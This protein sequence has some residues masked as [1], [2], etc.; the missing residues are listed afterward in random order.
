MMKKIHIGEMSLLEVLQRVMVFLDINKPYTWYASWTIHY[1]TYNNQ[2]TIGHDQLP[3]VPDG[4]PSLIFIKS[5][6][7]DST[8][9]ST[10]SEFLADLLRK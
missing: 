2:L 5:K 1:D 10:N 7:E 4:C 6:H 3:K 9:V 8:E